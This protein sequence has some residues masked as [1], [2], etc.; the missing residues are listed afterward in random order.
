MVVKNWF[1]R[2]AW[3]QRPF[4]QQ[5]LCCTAIAG[6]ASR[7]SPQFILTDPSTEPQARRS[8]RISP[9]V[10]MGHLARHCGA[11]AAQRVENVNPPGRLRGK[12]D[13]ITWPRS[14]L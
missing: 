1:G 12:A 6:R 3:A 7:L 2:V 13:T 5:L 8:R 4:T 9:L 14:M 11:R 10:K